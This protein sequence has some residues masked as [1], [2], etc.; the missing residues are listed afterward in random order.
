MDLLCPNIRNLVNYGVC[1][2]RVA[3]AHWLL[4]DGC[5]PTAA[6]AATTTQ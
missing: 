5:R 2:G 6:A 1:E 4:I 3:E